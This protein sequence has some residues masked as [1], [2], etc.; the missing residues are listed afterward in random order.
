MFTRK[1]NKK[2]KP[3]GKPI[4][5][6]FEL[7][8]SSAMNAATAGNAGNYQ[9]DWRSTKRVKKKLTTLL[10]PVPFRRSTTPRPTRSA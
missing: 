2:H 9:V 3:V 4:L 6:G 1:L 7:Q 5:T 10:H 8:F